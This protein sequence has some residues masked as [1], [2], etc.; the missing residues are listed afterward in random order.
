MLPEDEENFN[1]G[2][3]PAIPALDPSKPDN[4]LDL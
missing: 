3:S 4:G 2:T 1:L